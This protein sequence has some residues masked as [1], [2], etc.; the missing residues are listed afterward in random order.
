MTDERVLL[1]AIAECVPYD[2]L[3]SADMLVWWL[4]FRYCLRCCRH[5]C[6]PALTGSGLDRAVA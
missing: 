1:D 6:R 4:P 5:E 3:H 2:G